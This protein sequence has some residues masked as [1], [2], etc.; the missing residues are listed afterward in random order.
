MAANSVTALES[1]FAIVKL[2]SVAHGPCAVPAFNL[3]EVMR[4][5]NKPQMVEAVMFFTDQ[6]I[7]KQMLYPEF[8]AVL[9]GMVNMPEFTDQQMQA[10]YVLINPRLLVR[11]L[12]FFYI[13]FDEKGA[14]DPSWNIPLRHLAERAGR[15]PD[16]GAGPIRLACRSQSSVP[17][18]QMHLWDPDLSPKHNHI[19]MVRDAVKSNTLGVLSEDSY[20]PI[21]VTEQLTIAAEERWESASQMDANVAQLER[22]KDQ[23]QRH[24]AAQIIKQQRL[25]IST[26]ETQHEEQLTKLRIKHQAELAAQQ[27]MQLQLQQQLQQQE[28]LNVELKQQLTQQ[29]ESLNALR[30]DLQ[31]RLRAFEQ[32]EREAVESLRV[33]FEHELQARIAVAVVEYKEQV[34]IRDVELAYKTEHEQQLL[35]ELAQLKKQLQDQAGQSGEQI[36]ERL[37]RSGVVFVACHPGVGHITIP[38]Q[39]MTLYQEKTMQYVAKKC[40][41]TEDQYM[42]WLA[43]YENPVC[44]VKFDEHTQCGLP[45]A[46]VNTPSGFIEGESNR[47]SKHKK[48]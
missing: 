9:D 20:E 48:I 22:E 19:L 35:N 29:A 37:S 39:D 46:R 15:G 34:A 31:A 21:I 4:L 7:S 14:A 36:L 38:L 12:V 45:L 44:S 10:V 5:Q 11:S 13:D 2:E 26:L 32:H 42:R 40:A 1:G 28:R 25:R 30:A 8:E 6:K 41:V 18:H 17:W 27:Q 33:Q 16:L 3:R 43:H 24:K 47:C 23:E